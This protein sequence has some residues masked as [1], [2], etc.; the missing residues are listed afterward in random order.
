MPAHGLRHTRA[1]EQTREGTPVNVIRDAL[2]RT[3]L[4]IKHLF[5][6]DVAPRP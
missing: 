5:V 2:G 4:A 3:S 6:R 1:A